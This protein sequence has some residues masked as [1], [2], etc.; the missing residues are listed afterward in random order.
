MAQS[1][2]ERFEKH[3]SDP[4]PGFWCYDAG[5]RRQRA[6]YL[7]RLENRPGRPATEKE[8]T[9]AARKL[10]ESADDILEFYR[11]HNG[12]HLY[13]FIDANTNGPPPRFRILAPAI[14]FFPIAKWAAQTRTLTEAWQKMGLADF[15]ESGYLDGVAFGEI[16]LSG[17]YFVYSTSEM[18]RGKILYA[19]HDEPGREPMADGFCQ[20]LDL[21]CHNPVQFL[22]AAGC[23]ARYDDGTGVQR[24]PAKYVADV[25]G[26]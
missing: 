17:N 13:H 24:I 23:Y 22:N 18:P 2:I 5:D 15:V 7:A 16:C 3:L 10:G 8:L 12:L 25:S 9:R 21:I 4:A 14:T 26:L 1:A 11:R 20:F 19:D 6:S